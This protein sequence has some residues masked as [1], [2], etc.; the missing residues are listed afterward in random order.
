MSGRKTKKEV[1]TAASTVSVSTPPKTS[2]K[3]SDP[4][5]VSKIMKDLTT[6]FNECFHK[7]SCNVD[8]TSLMQANPFIQN[9]RLKSINTFPSSYSPEEIADFLHSP[10]TNE[11]QLRA[12]SWYL[13]ASQYLYYKIIRE[14]ADVPLFNYYVT[15]PILQGTSYTS[16]DIEGEE[17]YVD[18]WLKAF[19]VKNTLKKVSL[20]VKREGKCVYVFRQGIDV[21]REEKIPHYVIWQKLPSEYVKLTAM[22]EHG[23]I[24]S[25]NFMLFLRPGFSP[26]QYPEFIQKIWADIRQKGGVTKDETTGCCVPDINVLSNYAFIENG[27]TL[28]GILECNA[29]QEYMFWVQL[30]QDLCFTFCSDT[31]NP[32]VVPDTMGLFNALQELADYSVLAGL[33]ASSPLTAVLT[34]QAEAVPNAEPGQN[35]T[36]LS[37]AVM[38]DFQDMFN[39]LVSGNIQAFF[40]PFK[41]IK[42]HSLPNIPNASDIKTK[43][44]Q[45][46]IS[47]AGE[48]GTIPA[49]D[50]PSVA[51]IKG[52]QAM[53]A[54]QYDFVTRQYE[55]ILN[56]LLKKQQVLKHEWRVHLWGDIYSISSSILTLRNLVSSGMSFLLPQLASA[57]DMSMLDLR[58][59]NKYLKDHKVYD[60]LQVVNLSSKDKESSSGGAGTVGRPPIADGEVENDNT[61]ASKDAGNN[62]S[63]VKVY[64]QTSSNFCKICGE[65]LKEGERLFCENCKEA[66]GFEED[67]D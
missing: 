24:A 60:D 3:K 6:L 8:P 37:P 57:Y 47:T 5:Q 11:S 1:D 48:G 12:A 43:A 17:L 35:Q 28:K 49:T 40:A 2:K 56:M 55:A 13:S 63:D 31:S 50:K 19:D 4:V 46:F 22:G 20:D 59:V 45:N 54:A 62:V 14:A 15:P 39:S 9:Q 25:F 27:T 34:G 52:A 26:E 33:I 10:Q 65:E 58:S 7:K 66:Y 51:M 42:L 29:E 64:S 36:V 41:D 38:L 61:A 44:V 30:P 53:A 16:K 67:Y 21:K 18:R 32:W 23:F